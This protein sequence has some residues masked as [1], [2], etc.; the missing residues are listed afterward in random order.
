MEK[1]NLEVIKQFV[2]SRK[3]RW[4]NHILIRLL[5]RNINQVDV[6]QALLNGEIKGK[7]VKELLEEIIQNNDNGVNELGKF[8]SVHTKNISSYKGNVEDVCEQSNYFEDGENTTKNVENAKK[9]IKNLIEKIEEEKLYTVKTSTEQGAVYAV[10][11]SE[12]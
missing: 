5:Q 9:E 1:L 12:K 4:T 8:V 11:I 2:N 3:I 10:E 7:K 6:E